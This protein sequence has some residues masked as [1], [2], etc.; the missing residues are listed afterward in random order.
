[1]LEDLQPTL[2]GGIM[3]YR[4]IIA[5]SILCCLVVTSSS[6]KKAPLGDPSNP[7][8][9]WFMP[10][11]DAAVYEENAPKLKTF[12]EES[13]G[14]SVKTELANSYVDIIKALGQKKADAAF[15]NSLGYLLA[16]DWAGAEAILQYVY[17]DLYKSYSGE[18]ITRVGSGIDK[19]SDINGKVIAFTDPYSASGYLYPLKYLKD[20]DIKPSKSVYAGS[21]LKVVE[22]VYNG[23]ADAGAIYH[24][25]WATRGP[26]KDARSLLAKKYPDV[27]STIKV[28]AQTDEIP[29][30]PVAVRKGLPSDMKAKLTKTLLQFSKTPEGRRTLMELYGMTGLAPVDDA[31]YDGIRQV[32]RDL[33]KSIQDTVPGGTP[34]YRTFMEPGLD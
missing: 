2:R 14:L 5:I 15:I 25:G 11:K 12:L 8:K 3:K 26:S 24:E 18:F 1:M 19:P 20:K 29:N 23:E 21:H 31:A 27:F 32:V 30:G 9:L 16:N 4:L 34:Y 10:Q 17:G 22:M 13:M 28:L 6:C 7:L 33:G